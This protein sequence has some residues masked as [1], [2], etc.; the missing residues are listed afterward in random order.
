MLSK[1]G[2]RW[3]V[4]PAQAEGLVNSA[5]AGVSVEA[6]VQAERI[7]NVEP[8]SYFGPVGLTSLTEMLQALQ[9]T[10]NQEDIVT[11]FPDPSYG[12]GSVIKIYRAQ[13]VKLRDGKKELNYRT[14][15]PTIQDL[16]NEVNVELGDQDIINPFLETNIQTAERTKPVSITIT[17]VQE[18]DVLVKEVIEFETIEKKDSELEK[19]TTKVEQAGV[20]GVREKTYHVRREDGEEVSRQLTKTEVT[21][22]PVTKIVRIGTKIKVYGT[23]TA[24]WYTKSL[25]HVA[26]HN[27]IPRGTKVRVVNTSNG[28]STVVTVVGGGLAGAE[29]DLSYDAFSEI[30][31]PSAGRLPVRVEKVYD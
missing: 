15:Q 30:G 17:R 6:Q 8:E 22:K 13:T 9:V 4:A 3:L 16:L 23:G 27:T 19:G 28:K 18:T 11:A 25:N 24:T 12:S 26:A 14:W 2:E 29:I 1:Q 21:K 20:N 7:K 5:V 31:S 10:V